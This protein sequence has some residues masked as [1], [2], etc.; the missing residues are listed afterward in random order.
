MPASLTSCSASLPSSKWRGSV[1]VDDLQH[2]LRSLHWITGLVATLRLTRAA[3]GIEQCVVVVNAARCPPIERP[4]Q[5]VRKEPGATAVTWIPNGA[6]SL[7]STSLMPSSAN[8][9]PQYHA[10]PGIV[11]KPHGGDVEDMAAAPGAVRQH[12]LDQRGR[13]EHVHLNCCRSSAS[14]DSSRMPSWP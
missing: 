7:S 13:S 3:D 14:V 5:S 8:L 12:G 11:M 1:A 2:G 10:M 4:A 6:T 9:L